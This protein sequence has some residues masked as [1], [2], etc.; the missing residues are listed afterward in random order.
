MKKHLAVLGSFMLLAACSSTPKTN[1]DLGANK[2]NGSQ[3]NAASQGVVASKENSDKLSAKSEALSS[4]YFDTDKSEIKTQFLDVVKQQAEW[5]K[6]HKGEVV[7]VQGNT[8][9]RGSDEYN[10]A[11]G[12]RRAAAVHR[13]LVAQGVSAKRIKDVSFGKEKPAA[14]CHEEKCWEQNRRVDFVHQPG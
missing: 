12:H 3:V 1:S 10:L 9:E 4:I 8:D 11:L 6:V 7:T 14:T 5:M 13:M 2:T